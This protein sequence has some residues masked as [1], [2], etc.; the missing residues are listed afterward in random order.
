MHLARLGLDPIAAGAAL[1]R[2]LGSNQ[3]GVPQFQSPSGEFTT[4]QDEINR[5]A[6]RATAT[7]KGTAGTGDGKS[8]LVVNVV[9]KV[10]QA[11]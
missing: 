7:K 10:I 3:Y 11:I 2:G 4:T 1:Y 8:F 9:Q 5:A 6:A